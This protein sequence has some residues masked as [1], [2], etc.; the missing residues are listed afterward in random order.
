MG[1]LTATQLKAAEELAEDLFNLERRV[2]EH[3][4]I[5]RIEPNRLAEAYAEYTA[6][7][8]TSPAGFVPARDQLD[9]AYALLKPR[10]RRVHYFFDRVKFVNTAM[11]LCRIKMMMAAE[12]DYDAHIKMKQIRSKLQHV[13]IY[14][15][16][17][18]AKLCYSQA[19]IPKHPHPLLA[20]ELGLRQPSNTTAI[21]PDSRPF[22]FP[23]IASAERCP[24]APAEVSAY[25]RNPDRLPDYTFGS[26][27]SEGVEAFRV[28]S[29]LSSGRKENLYYLVFSDEGPEAVARSTDD[30]F[31]LLASSERVL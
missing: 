12:T 28:A 21:A 4:A 22:E 7:P 11:F 14:S 17:F 27:N 30:F 25:R 29:I 3:A 13:D 18:H 15:F 20:Q 5:L 2:E 24:V 6:L 10:S 9:D 23:M 19:H 16:K 1:R 31:T 26:T 8:D